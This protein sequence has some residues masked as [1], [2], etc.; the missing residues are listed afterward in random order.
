MAG[1]SRIGSPQNRTH[2]CL[3]YSWGFWTRWE[4][5][6][7]E[8]EKERLRKGERRKVAAEMEKRGE[9]GET[10]PQKH[11][12]EVKR[13]AFNLPT[14]SVN[15]IYQCLK[16]A[17]IHTR[18]RTHI[19]TH[20]PQEDGVLVI[21]LSLKVSFGAGDHC[22]ISYPPAWMSDPTQP[23]PGRPTAAAIPGKPSITAPQQP[24]GLLTALAPFPILTSFLT[25]PILT[26]TWQ[27]FISI[28][29]PAIMK[30]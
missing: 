11:Y 5:V 18:M 16:H 1:L 6:G 26:T 27:G 24:P 12:Q 2:W 25:T 8:Q 4:S 22:C 19:H 21:P 13:E 20:T 14:F 17:Q 23:K 9:I 30:L 15:H 28:V 3:A 10:G 7:T 29:K